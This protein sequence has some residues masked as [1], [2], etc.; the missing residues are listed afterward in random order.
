VLLA[1]K[2]RND[3]TSPEVSVIRVNQLTM[4]MSSSSISLITNSRSLITF[5]FLPNLCLLPAHLLLIRD[6]RQGRLSE[7]FP[8]Q[9][10]LF[11]G[12]GV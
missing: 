7:H 5:A 8:E 2:S 11:L 10:H 4:A 9:S 3:K 12:K 1:I 6:V